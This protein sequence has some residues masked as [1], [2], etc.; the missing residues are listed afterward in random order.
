MTERRPTRKP[1]FAILVEGGLVQSVVAARDHLVYRLIDLDG[2][3]PED[4]LIGD[5]ITDAADVDIDVFS[6][7]A[8]ASR[9]VIQ[10][11]SAPDAHLED[12]SDTQQRGDDS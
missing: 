2:A 7:E 4:W 5:A 6:R 8:I 1:A 9:Q 3:T 11:E 12:L 10:H